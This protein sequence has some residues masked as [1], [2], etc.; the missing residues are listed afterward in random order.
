VGVAATWPMTAAP[1]EPGRDVRAGVAQA[2][3]IGHHAPYFPPTAI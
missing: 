2:P 1:I 3:A